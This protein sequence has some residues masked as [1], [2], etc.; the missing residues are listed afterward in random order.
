MFLY[1]TDLIVQLSGLRANFRSLCISKQFPCPSNTLNNLF[2]V[3][4]TIECFMP[5]WSCPDSGI[6]VN[7]TQRVIRDWSSHLRWICWRFLRRASKGHPRRPTRIQRKGR[8]PALLLLGSPHL[9]PTSIRMPPQPRILLHQTAPPPRQA[10]TTM[11]AP[12]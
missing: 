1:L 2:Q 9:S 8:I 4:E 11:T 7:S 3:R 10:Q 5:A 12:R 6:T